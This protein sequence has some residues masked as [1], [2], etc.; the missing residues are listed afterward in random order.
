MHSPSK[1]NEFNHSE[2]PAR[3]LLERLGWTYVPRDSLASQGGGDKRGILQWVSASAADALVTAGSRQEGVMEI[4]VGPS[5]WGEGRP[6][7]IEAL[8]RNVASHLLCYIRELMEGSIIVL[9][10]ATENDNPMT[11]YRSTPEDHQII[12]LQARGRRWSKFSYQ[13]AHELCHVLSRYEKLKCSPNGWFHEALCELASVFVLLSM[14]ESWKVSP[15]FQHW[16]DYAQHLGDYANEL[17]ARPECQVPRGTSLAQWLSD[18]EDSLRQDPYQR[19]K[20]A[21]VAYELLPLFQNEPTGWN[22]VGHLPNSSAKLNDYLRE[23]YTKVDVVDK[24]FL[25]RT[26]EA[27]E[28]NP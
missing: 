25:K 14:A 6:S 27:F 16:K 7:D 3:R 23:W 18:Q 11:L 10:T 21:I 17:L 8:L 5:H 9:P 12:L 2:A 22:A 19:D 24:P 13:F 28:L 4:R 1:L 26:L 15:P 20:N